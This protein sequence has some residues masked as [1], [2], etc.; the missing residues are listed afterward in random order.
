MPVIFETNRK[1]PGGSEIGRLLT[2]AVVSPQFCQLLLADPD[3]AISLGFNGEQFQ[4]AKEEQ[5][6]ILSIKARSLAEFANQLVLSQETSRHIPAN[7]FH[8][9]QPVYASVGLA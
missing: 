3:K 8:T 6:R 7:R 5:E 1:T 2:A 9:D 4:F